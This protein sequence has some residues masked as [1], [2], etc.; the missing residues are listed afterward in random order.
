MSVLAC[1]PARL[2]STR[3]KNK[4]LL[5]KHGIPLVVYTAR[6]V[7]KTGCA[8]QVLVA[9]DHKDIIDACR[10][11]GIE[12]V[13]TSAE[14]SSGT[15][16]INEAA[17][18]NFET[19]INVQGDMP[20]VNSSCLQAVLKALEHAPM[21]T[22]AAPFKDR[23]QYLDTNKVKVLVNSA[24]LAAYFSRAALPFVRDTFSDSCLFTS[25]FHHLGIYAFR[26]DFLKIFTGLPRSTW[27]NAEK[28]EQLRALQ[29]GYAVGV[30]IIP[31]QLHEIDTTE[32]FN[33]FLEFPDNH[34]A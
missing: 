22:I 16:R 8:D 30:E 13:M 33:K 29:S 17:G 7:Q 5:E 26:R 28:L 21:G 31:D 11:F 32:D 20:M 1:I 12:A 25:V 14:H 3:L 34:N 23:A 9:A 10:R 15:D 24:G 4:M 2:A 27:E 18:S 19:V 6:S